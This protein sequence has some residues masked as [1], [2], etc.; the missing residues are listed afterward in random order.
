[1]F[2]A[3]ATPSEAPTTAEQEDTDILSKAAGPYT[4]VARN[5]IT[6]KEQNAALSSMVTSLRQQLLEAR[7]HETAMRMTQIQLLTKSLT[8]KQL[9]AQ[10]LQPVIEEITDWSKAIHRAE[11]RQLDRVVTTESYERS[12]KDQAAAAL[13]KRQQTI[14]Q[15]STLLTELSKP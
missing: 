15:L 9:L 4:T 3:T 13:A 7:D 5:N 12:A 10:T 11:L 8:N 2:K 14:D 6:L 1:M